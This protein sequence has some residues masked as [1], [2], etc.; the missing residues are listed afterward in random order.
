MKTIG[1]I[2]QHRTGSTYMIE[3]IPMLN[4]KQHNAYEVFSGWIPRFVVNLNVFLGNGKPLP[5]SIA[6]LCREIFSDYHKK[7][8]RHIF[9]LQILKDLKEA[10]NDLDYDYFVFK[11]LS[12]QQRLGIRLSEIIDLCDYMV[13]AYRHNTL[14]N[15]ISWELA[16][17]SGNWVGTDKNKLKYQAKNVKVTWNIS[18]YYLFKQESDIYYDQYIP[19][20]NQ[21]NTCLIKY[22]EFIKTDCENLWRNILNKFDIHDLIIQN[23]SQQIKLNDKENCADYFNNPEQ[24][25]EDYLYLENNGDIFYNGFKD[26]PIMT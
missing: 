24:F 26:I 12:K 15:Y 10:V 13:F 8:K 19:Y 21:D 22:E 1:Y 11:F 5:N 14:L 7:N 2:S 23:T 3:H 16:N 18:K 6:N 17:S 4:L 25:R 9:N 20:L